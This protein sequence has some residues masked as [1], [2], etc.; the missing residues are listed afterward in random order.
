MLALVDMY[1]TSISDSN[2]N[3]DV[4]GERRC[5]AYATIYN[6]PSHD[7]CHFLPMVSASPRTP[8]LARSMKSPDN[9][10]SLESVDEVRKE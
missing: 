4:D 2:V 10:A 1:R 8:V 7:K 5:V 6:C 9:L 3:S